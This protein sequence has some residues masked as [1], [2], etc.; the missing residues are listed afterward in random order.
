MYL[1]LE[2][3]DAD[4]AQDDWQYEKTESEELISPVH[5]GFQLSEDASVILRLNLAVAQ[6]IHERYD[7]RS[8]PKQY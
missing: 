8:D 6:S 4:H 1:V 5:L 7:Y 2:D 3:P